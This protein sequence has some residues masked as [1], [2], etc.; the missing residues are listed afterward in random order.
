MAGA[1][2]FIRLG[3]SC[4]AGYKASGL[5]LNLSEPVSSAKRQQQSPYFL[6]S[7]AIKELFYVWG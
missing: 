7:E 3:V 2:R 6:G 1:G 4:A 5:P